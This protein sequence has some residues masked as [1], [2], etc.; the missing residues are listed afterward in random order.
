M[1]DSSFLALLNTQ[2]SSLFV[3][4]AVRSPGGAAMSPGTSA[5]RQSGCGARLLSM[6]K[7]AGPVAPTSA[8]PPASGPKIAHLRISRP[9]GL[10]AMLCAVLAHPACLPGLSEPLEP[11]LVAVDRAGVPAYPRLTADNTCELVL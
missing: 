3:L 4:S 10:L 5:H 1:M 11:M 7:C 9:Y 8:I 2:N 6:R